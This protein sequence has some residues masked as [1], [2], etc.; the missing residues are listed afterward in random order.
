MAKPATLLVSTLTDPHRIE[1]HPIEYFDGYSQ[2]GANEDIVE[3]GHD[4]TKLRRIDLT[5]MRVALNTC[6]QPATLRS[7]H[8]HDREYEVVKFRRRRHNPTLQHSLAPSP[9]HPYS[10]TSAPSKIDLESKPA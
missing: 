9:R 8:L 6:Q 4:L 3:I 1:L 10:S 7:Q 2:R 5:R